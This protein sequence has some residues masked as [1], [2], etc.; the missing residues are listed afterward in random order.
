MGLVFWGFLPYN[1]VACNS[2]S[3]LLPVA[4]LNLFL[5][6]PSETHRGQNHNARLAAEK[7]TTSFES[8]KN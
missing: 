6:Y 4:I 5:Q 2:L 8:L 7:Y 1:R 3:G